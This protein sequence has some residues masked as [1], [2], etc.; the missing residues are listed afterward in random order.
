MNSSDWAASSH[1]RNERVLH[2][3]MA[4]LLVASFMGNIF[5]RRSIAQNIQQIMVD[6]E[7][8]TSLCEMESRMFETVANS[9]RR[10][11]E[12]DQEY[13]AMLAKIPNTIADSDVLSSVRGVVSKS[14]CNLI[15]FRP[16]STVDRKEFKNRSYDLQLDGS[17]KQLV[18]FFD[19]LQNAPFIF[20]VSRFK[21]TEPNSP[22]SNCKAEMEL[23]TVFDHAW[24]SQEQSRNE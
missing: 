23:R 16:T 9:K 11:E 7:D 2:S 5:L 4:I 20:Q 8:C 12:L 14:R 22:G 17:F 18:H 19:S 1:I 13:Q 3:L 24:A 15:D 21:I 6:T 10:K